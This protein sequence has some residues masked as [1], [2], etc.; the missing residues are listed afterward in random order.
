MLCNGGQHHHIFP[1]TATRKNDAR[2]GASAPILERMPD[3]LT[4]DLAPNVPARDDWRIQLYL[5]VNQPAVAWSH[6]IARAVLH[7]A[8][9]TVGPQSD[10]GTEGEITRVLR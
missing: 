8:E 2:A 3:M 10:R 5:L 4:E 6:L 1:P 9:G 7:P